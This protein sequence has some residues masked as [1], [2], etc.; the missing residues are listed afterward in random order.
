METIFFF[1]VH[2]I[3]RRIAYG[4]VGGGKLDV[5]VL[6]S[7]GYPEG[8][9]GQCVESLKSRLAGLEWLEEFEWFDCKSEKA[10]G[11]LYLRVGLDFSAELI[12]EVA[13]FF[14]AADSVARR[15]SG[16]SLR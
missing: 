15:N 3:A 6:F 10:Y 7:G 13:H 11:E 2:P 4:R 5:D 9:R 16:G 8:D 12:D 1:H 14:A